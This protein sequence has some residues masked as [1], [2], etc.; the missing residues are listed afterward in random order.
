MRGSSY[1][2]VP[3]NILQDLIYAPGCLSTDGLDLS[4]ANAA[5]DTAFSPAP[6][7]TN[8]PNQQNYTYPVSKQ[9]FE[10]RH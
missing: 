2:S 6:L 7:F 5:T 10:H 9:R 1:T 4:D 3:Q 8:L